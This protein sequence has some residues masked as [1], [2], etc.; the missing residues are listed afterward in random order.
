M[1]EKT[2]KTTNKAVQEILLNYRKMCL[3]VPS[4]TPLT[5]DWADA[6]ILTFIEN[7]WK[8]PKVARSKKE[9]R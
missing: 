4:I 1:S 9:I 3:S 2:I 6:I 8:M 7:G 5:S